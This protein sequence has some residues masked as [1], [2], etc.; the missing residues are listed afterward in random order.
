VAAA[1]ILEVKV[2]AS[3]DWPYCLVSPP[4]LLAQLLVDSNALLAHLP[5]QPTTLF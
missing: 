4:A 5:C 3:F 2:G 1:K